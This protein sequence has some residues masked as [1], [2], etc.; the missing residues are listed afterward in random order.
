MRTEWL[1]PLTAIEKEWLRGV[2]CAR[3]AC[4]VFPDSDPDDLV[5]FTIVGE[6]SFLFDDRIGFDEYDSL[7]DLQSDISR[8]DRILETGQVETTVPGIETTFAKCL[9]QIYPRSVIHKLEERSARSSV[10]KQSAQPRRL[11]SKSQL[12][13]PRDETAISTAQVGVSRLK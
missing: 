11:T 6:W 2:D 13:P 4:Q 3:V 5:V 8:F 7:E 1:G 9:Q 10:S 12:L